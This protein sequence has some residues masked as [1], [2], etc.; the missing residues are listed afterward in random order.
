MAKEFREFAIKGNV[1]DLAVGLIVGAEFGKIVNSLVQ[2]VIM[3][4]IGLL[5][6]NVDFKNLYFTLK[7]GAAAPGPYETLIDAQKA[8][9]VTLNVGNFLTAVITFTIVAFAVFLVVKLVN[10]LRRESP[11]QPKPLA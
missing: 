4:P 2:D 9:A 3:P 7:P 6:G 8:G 11:Q 1:I 5:I 10:R